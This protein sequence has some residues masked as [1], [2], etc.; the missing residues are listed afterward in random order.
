VVK[1]AG[2]ETTLSEQFETVKITDAGQTMEP[3]GV[4]APQDLLG[5]FES[6]G[7]VLPSLFTVINETVGEQSQAPQQDNQPQTEEGAGEAEANAQ[8]SQESA[9]EQAAQQTIQNATEAAVVQTTT[10]ETNVQS[11]DGAPVI[12]GD[13]LGLSSGIVGVPLSTPLNLAGDIGTLGGVTATSPISPSRLNTV[14]LRAFEPMQQPPAQIFNPT[15]TPVPAPVPAPPPILNLSNPS[16][17]GVS[18]ITDGLNN[19]IGYSLSALGDTNNDGFDDFVFTNNVN[20]QNDSYF[21]N[22][23]ISSLSSAASRP[24]PTVTNTQ[25]TV[26]AGIGD[27]NGDGSKDYVIGQQGADLGGIT[28]G[29][30]SIIN[31]GNTA[32]L[33]TFGSA[34]A[35]SGNQVGSSVSMAGDFNNDGYADVIIGAPGMNSGDGAAYFI[36]G[37]SSGTIT[38]LALGGGTNPVRIDGIG[39][40]SESLGTNV[41]H[42]GDFNGD[43]YSDFALSAPM[44]NGGMGRV[45]FY[46][47]QQT[48]MPTKQSWD[49]SAAGQALG[50]KLFYA[51]DFNGDGKSDAFV[52]NADSTGKIFFGGGGQKSYDFGTLT[53]SAGGSVGDFNADGYDDIGLALADNSGTQIYILYGK[54]MADLPASFD[55]S[56]LQNPNNAFAMSY[57]GANMMD[58][59]TAINR[60]GDINGDGYDDHG[61]GVPDANGAANGDG[62]VIVVYGRSAG[63]AGNNFVGTTGNDVL[64]DGGQSGRF[65]SGGAGTDLFD[66]SNTNFLGIKGGG[67]VAG[68]YDTMRMMAGGLDFRNVDFE[69]ISGIERMQ[70]GEDYQ[71]MT[72]TLENI[73]N[74]LKTSDDGILKIENGGFT[75]T[76]LNIDA[77][78]NHTNAGVAEIANALNQMGNVNTQGEGSGFKHFAIG[79]YDLYIQSDTQVN[80]V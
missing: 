14:P 56:Y 65:L 16:A 74:L 73:F 24:N 10:A 62:G 49:G 58:G 50:S 57:N 26:I 40:S 42:L 75:D 18:V 79:G 68:Q 11:T 32:V 69:K 35:G 51:G 21:V 2:G 30:I 64:S 71:T 6:V 17:A 12:L 25:E 52:S 54:G 28:N 15:P 72:L 46:Y 47:G 45:D 22:G 33:A 27:F 19:K 76:V 7:G 36:Y 5:R 31:G 20:G 60:L 44:A 38:T 67:N 39:G 4:I 43:G 66:I 48:G 3:L 37:N 77:A 1:N 70:F 23:S 55:L 29:N 63:P 59:I 80:I 41:T 78:N 34:G 9:Q 13:F 53:L 61:I 8:D